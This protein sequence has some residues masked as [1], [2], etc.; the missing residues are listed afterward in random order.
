MTF[1]LYAARTVIVF[2]P[3]EDAPAIRA[4]S[5]QLSATQACTFP[6]LDKRI[7]EGVIR[8]RLERPGIYLLIG[9]FEDRLLVRIG[10]S[11]NV[12]RRLGN[13]AAKSAKTSVDRSDADLEDA[14]NDDPSIYQVW[15]TTVAFTSTDRTLTTGHVKYIESRLTEIAERN[16]TIRV[17]KGQTPSADAGALPIHEKATSEAF[18]RQ[19]ILLS[20]VFGYDFFEYDA[21]APVAQTRNQRSSMSTPT[22]VPH[23]APDMDVINVKYSNGQ[24]EASMRTNGSSVFVVDQG[25]FA[26]SDAVPT[27]SAASK[28]LRETLSA[29]GVLV[30]DGNRLR[31]TSDQEFK[32]LASVTQT[33]AGS[34]EYGMRV[35]KLDDGRTL[36]EWLASGPRQSDPP[37]AAGDFDEGQQSVG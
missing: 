17:I 37:G 13:H 6:A 7:D 20:G 18:I 23:S 19:A 12:Y 32:T 2:L 4:A 11:E 24:V 15:E 33:V 34:T 21:L 30:T 5:I 14:S 27:L 1:N 29:N 36:G 9:Q 10:Q 16:P 35:W 26:R 31:F 8:E 28:R 3:F 22:A 25:S